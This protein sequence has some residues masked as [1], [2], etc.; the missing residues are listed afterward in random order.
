MQGAIDVFLDP[1]EV[2]ARRGSDGGE[3]TLLPCWSEDVGESER[4]W[5]LEFSLPS[6]PA[7]D[8]TR[9]SSIPQSELSAPTSSQNQ[10]SS[11]VSL[12]L[13]ARWAKAASSSR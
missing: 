13:S 11:R 12:S 5:R 10:R 8:G 9:S 3:E 2:G 7:D 6:H 4:S 1:F